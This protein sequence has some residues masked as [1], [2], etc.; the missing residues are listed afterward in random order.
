MSPF[1]FLP[2]GLFSAAGIAL[3][4]WV[5]IAASVPEN[6]VEIR[7]PRDR[8]CTPPSYFESQDRTRIVLGWKDG[9]V[10]RS[11]GGQEVDSDPALV[12]Q[13]MSLEREAPVP[14]HVDDDVPWATFVTVIEQLTAR[15][16]SIELNGPIRR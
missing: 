5:S 6:V 11:V 12:L 13:L 7:F 15:G 14:L 16:I 4:G 3:C 1:T 2:A 9:H 8:S 10:V